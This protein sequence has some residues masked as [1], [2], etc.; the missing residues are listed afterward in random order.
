MTLLASTGLPIAYKPIEVRFAKK[1]I[2]LTD[3]ECW[4]W[5]GYK[6]KRWGYGRIGW[7]DS[8]YL[9]HRIAWMLA[10]GTLP[11]DNMCVCHTCDNPS[12]VNPTHLFIDSMSGN[13]Q[14]RARK[15]R[16][17]TKDSGTWLGG[18]PRKRLLV[19]KKGHPL[20]AENTYTSM[21]PKGLLRLC[22]ICKN[23]R[24]RRWYQREKL[25]RITLR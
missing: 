6:D 5:T 20:D 9:A 12:C 8:V 3:N 11:P 16:L 24:R 4:P 19:C 7:K 25:K 21:T 1:F 13:N 15:G 23:E 14:D 22:R 18:R 10:T 17:A 2:R